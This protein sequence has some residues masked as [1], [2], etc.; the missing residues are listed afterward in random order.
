MSISIIRKGVAIFLAVVMA[1]TVFVVVNGVAGMSNSGSGYTNGG[2][3]A[4]AARKVY[5]AKYS[6]KYHSTK[7]CWTLSRS[8]KIYA[9]TIKKAKRKGLKKCKVCW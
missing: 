6:K 8:K 4:E 7:Q 3:T 9:T 2:T 1:I 5:Y